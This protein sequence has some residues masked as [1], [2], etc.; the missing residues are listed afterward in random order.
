MHAPLPKCAECG[1][2]L[3]RL[4]RAAPAVHYAAPG[5]FSTDVSHFKNQIGA[6]RFARFEAER[7]ATM[8]RMKAGKPTRYEHAAEVAFGEKTNDALSGARR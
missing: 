7:D 2:R 1:G 4:F 3:R 5:F 8:R 6:E